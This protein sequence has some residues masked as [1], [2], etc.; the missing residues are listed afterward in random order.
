[1]WLKP[2]YTESNNNKNTPFCLFTSLRACQLEKYIVKVLVTS[3]LY[4]DTG[5]IHFSLW[6][7]CFLIVYVIYLCLPYKFC[8]FLTPS[9]FKIC[10]LFP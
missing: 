1:V 8:F 10:I 9:I 6:F 3:K 2:G 4:N 5:F 7:L